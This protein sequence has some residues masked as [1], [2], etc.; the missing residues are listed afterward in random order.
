MDDRADAALGRAISDTEA[1]RADGSRPASRLGTDA[2]LR[3]GV[4]AGVVLTARPRQWAKNVL[5]FAA[6]ATGGVLSHPSAVFEAI[7]A[8][9]V[10]C[11]VSSGAYFINDVVDRAG[12]R[13]HPSKRFR[14]VAAGEISARSAVV[15]GATLL[16]AGSVAAFAGG[17]LPLLIVVAGY[18]ALALS[19]TFVLRNMVLLDI[20]AIAGGFLIRAIVGGVATDVPLSMWFLMVASFG[21]LFIATGKRYSE[22]RQLGPGRSDQR[23]TLNEYTE[24][25]LRYIQYASSTVAISAYSL[26]AFEGVAGGSLWSELS[27][28]PFVIGIF[29]YGFLL[30][31]GQGGTPEEIVLRDRQLQLLGACWVSLVAIGVYL[32]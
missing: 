27:I 9:L 15:I 29:R 30:D 2:G 28:A 20:A 10:L 13:Q 11:I 4:I 7:V 26:W 31:Q 1:E 5:V 8:F 16:A 32:T 17:E 22:L 18:V 19:Y 24:S 25:Y 3:H 12:D 14:P 21:S 23:P 6:P